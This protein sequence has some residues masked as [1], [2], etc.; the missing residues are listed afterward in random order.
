MKKI[1]NREVI[2]FILSMFI[3]LGVSFYFTTCYLDKDIYFSLLRWDVII[4]N[5]VPIFSFLLIFY[6]LTKRLWVSFGINSLI[7]VILGLINQNK[8]IYRDDVLKIEDFSL[9]FE[10]W[11]MLERYKVSISLITIFIILVLIL[12]MVYLLNSKKKL[13]FKTKDRVMLVI[14]IVMFMITNNHLVYQKEFFWNSVG[15]KSNINQW[16]ETRQ[17]QV[18]G[19]IYPLIYTMYD[20]INTPPEGYDEKEIEEELSKYEEDKIPEDKKVNVIAIMLEAY[21]DFSVFKDEIPFTEDIYVGWHEVEN[22]S[23]HGHL[24]TTVFGGGTIETERAFL[25]GMQN[26][27]SYRKPTNSFVWYFKNNGYYT[28]ALHP[29]IGSFYNRITAD[30]NMGFDDFFYYENRLAAIQEDY[31]M[32]KEFFE[33]IKEDFEKAKEENKPLFS[34]S[35]TYQNHGP[36]FDENYDGKEFYFTKKNW[37]SD[38]VYNLVNQYFSGVKETTLAAKEL[39]DYFDSQDE[40]VIVVMFGDHKPYLGDNMVGYDELNIY[41][42]AFKEQGFLNTYSTPFIIHLNESAE[43]TLSVPSKGEREDISPIY[44]MNEVFDIMGVKG[45]SFAQYLREQREVLPVITNTFVNYKGKYAEF[46]KY[47]GSEPAKIVDKYKKVNYYNMTK[48]NEK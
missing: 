14:L 47:D 16:V 33:V 31:M 11:K 44:L 21:N 19:F 24:V 13:E 20:G 40:P 22:S 37:M 10:T 34:F 1:F 42:N 5:V 32:D 8:L 28:E 23:I 17:C 4:L 3:L 41:I 39:V 6:L 36:Y 2:N 45:T 43:R 38:E 15:D 7:L 35:V 18:R 12:W 48:F 46:D 9:V 30:S 25:T 29:I 27:P 26:H